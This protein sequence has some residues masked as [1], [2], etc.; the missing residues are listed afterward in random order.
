MSHPLAWVDDTVSIGPRTRIWQFASVIRGTVLGADCN[1][2]SNATLDGPRF[3]DRCIICQGVAMGPGFHF[4]DDCFIGPNVVLCNDAF[5]ASNKTGFDIEAF[6]TGGV[7]IRVG[8][9][10]S[11]GAGAIILPGVTLGDYSCVGAGVVC[12]RNVP[13]NHMLTRDGRLREIPQ[14]LRRRR[15]KLLK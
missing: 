3:G 13:A 2:A 4:G 8:N 14:A 9:G 1:V 6:Q 12:D 5:P 10:V 15:M 7:T 11:I